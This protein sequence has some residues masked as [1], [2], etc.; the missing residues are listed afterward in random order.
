MG[1]WS[2][3]I[4]CGRALSGALAIFRSISQVAL[5]N[6]RE[7]ARKLCPREKSLMWKPVIRWN[8]QRHLSRCLP[9]W[10]GC[11][12]FNDYGTDVASLLL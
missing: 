8:R 2:N 11:W 12:N 7:L 4:S 9:P 10:R 5:E 3:T 6:C 1:M